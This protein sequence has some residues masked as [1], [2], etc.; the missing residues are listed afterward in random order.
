MRSNSSVWPITWLAIPRMHNSFSDLGWNPVVVVV[1]ASDPRWKTRLSETTPPASD[2]LDFSVVTFCDAAVGIVPSR[3]W[4]PAVH[5]RDIVPSNIHD[6]LWAEAYSQIRLLI[7]ESPSM[8]CAGLNCY[9]HVLADGL[10]RYSIWRYLE[11]SV[12]PTLVLLPIGSELITKAKSVLY[13]YGWFSRIMGSRAN[14]ERLRSWFILRGPVGRC[15]PSRASLPDAD[16]SGVLLIVEDG[17]SALH[18]RPA[19]AIASELVERGMLPKVLTSNAQ[20][21]AAFREQGHQ[22]QTIRP[23]SF[24][25]FSA[26]VFWHGIPLLFGVLREL[27]RKSSLKNVIDPSFLTWL[28]SS[29][30]GYIIRRMLL[31]DGIAQAGY[32]SSVKVVLTLGETFPLAIAGLNW[33]HSRDVPGVGVMPALIGGRPDNMDFPALIHLVYGEQAVEWMLKQNVPAQS[34]K[35]VGSTN[36]ERV[37]GRDRSLDL[38]LVRTAL[39]SWRPVDKLVVLATEALPNPSIELGPILRACI[40]LGNIYIVIRVHPADNVEAIKNCVLSHTSVGEKVIVVA[41]DN[42]EAFL[43]VSH[44]LVCI[45]SN[46]A[47]LAGLLG[48]PTLV[49]TFGGRHRA[50]DFAA[51]GFAV[52]CECE[53][54]IGDLIRDLTQ[55]GTYRRQVIEQMTRQIKRYVGKADGNSQRHIVDVVTHLINDGRLV[56]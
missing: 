16:R 7:Q 14:L 49:P 44:L 33:A 40:D 31:V 17:V 25:L 51:G 39:P 46:I 43:H 2:F 53:E 42:L 28:R 19:L 56:E 27:R 30:L 24:L 38:E 52:A 15:Q 48:T 47:I 37:L 35:V 36:F 23:R 1:D 29:V 18:C 34:I 12:K 41:D 21:A 4:R 26:N 3:G 50:I 5:W 45:Q 8:V 55:D 11:A 22:V 10:T 32:E 9:L 20:I 6:D 13:S 54:K